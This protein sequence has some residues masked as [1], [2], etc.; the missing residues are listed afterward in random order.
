MFSEQKILQTFIANRAT[1]Q[2]QLMNV[3]LSCQHLMHLLA[4]HFTPECVPPL[5]LVA[6]YS[7]LSGA[8]R[9][10]ST[11]ASALTLLSRLDIKHAGERF[12]SIILSWNFGKVSFATENREFWN[13]LVSLV[14]S[15]ERFEL[16]FTTEIFLSRLPPQQFSELMPLAFENV[17]S[18]S[19]TASPMYALCVKH[20]VHSLFHH[21]PTNFV[22]G[23]SLALSGEF[24]SLLGGFFRFLKFIC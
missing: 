20:F 24:F 17:I 1:E 22:A 6:I 4:A 8:I 12:A 10:P 13:Y 9:T 21:F 5:E 23:L 15:V 3:A 19:D 18:L 2:T 14:S 16:D 7:S 11:S